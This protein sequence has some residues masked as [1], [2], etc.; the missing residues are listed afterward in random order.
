[1]SN[2]KD[3][4]LAFPRENY[5]TGDA[6]GQRGMSLRDYFA[7]RAMQGIFTADYVNGIESE[8][9]SAA[10]MTVAGLAYGMADAMIKA[11]EQGK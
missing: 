8:D 10:L 3:G 5:Q 9:S 2:I 4:G 7:A 1:M 6:P 11:R